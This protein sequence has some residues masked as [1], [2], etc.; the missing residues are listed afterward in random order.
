MIKHSKHNQ[1][2]NTDSLYDRLYDRITGDHCHRTSGPGPHPISCQRIWWLN[3]GCTMGGSRAP[4]HQVQID[5]W[6]GL[7]VLEVQHDMSLYFE[8]AM[9]GWPE[10]PLKCFGI[11][12]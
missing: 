6:N 3:A 7:T 8:Y 11:E 4:N 10:Y 1:T 5:F 9:L 2:Y 12:P